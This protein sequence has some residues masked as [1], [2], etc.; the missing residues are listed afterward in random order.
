MRQFSLDSSHHNKGTD[1]PQATAVTPSALPTGTI[2]FLFTDIEGSTPLWEKYPAAMRD[3]GC[4]APPSAPPG[5]REPRRAVFKVVGDRFQ[6]VFRLPRPGPLR[7]AG[8]SA[9]RS[10]RTQAWPEEPGPIQVRMGL[11]A[12][13]AELAGSDYAVSHTL[14]R[15]AGDERRVRRPDP[16]PA[17]GRPRFAGTR[18]GVKGS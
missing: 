9:A 4:P 2:T 1:F 5:D 17:G 6:A 16:A 10:S 14:P 12:G 11:H 8:G 7:R 13:P 18:R 3:R 15:L